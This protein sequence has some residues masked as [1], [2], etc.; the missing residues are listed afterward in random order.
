MKRSMVRL[1]TNA[2]NHRRNGIIIQLD[3]INRNSMTYPKMKMSPPLRTV[4]AFSLVEITLALGVAAFCLITVLGLV[5]IAL[6][7]QQASV[8]QTTANQILSQQAADLRASVRYPPGLAQQLNDQ[9]KILRG[10]WAEVGTPDTLYYTNEGT[11]TGG[12]TP[13]TVPSDAVFRLTLT[14]LLP[15]TDSTTSLANITV[16]WP[17]Q[18]D[19]ATGTPAGSVQT[20]IAINR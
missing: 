6:K 7:T 20:F 8:Q 13:A 18:V 9:Q 14:Y 5:P 12:L 3:S 15:P 19:P 16:S 4:A 1:L 2:D 17:A 11:Q 10:H